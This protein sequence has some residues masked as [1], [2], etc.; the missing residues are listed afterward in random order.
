[1]R[2]ASRI[3]VHEDLKSRSFLS[4]RAFIKKP[5]TKKVIHVKKSGARVW[6]SFRYNPTRIG[7]TVSNPAIWSRKPKFAKICF[8]MRFRYSVRLGYLKGS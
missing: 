6:I 8:I 4:H 1:M 2:K 3:R 7:K 5:E